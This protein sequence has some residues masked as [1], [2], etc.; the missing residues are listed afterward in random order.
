M[1]PRRHAT[2]IAI[3]SDIHGNRPALEA[4][5]GA[6]A[7]RDITRWWCLGDLVGYGADPLF[8]M[9]TCMT[10]AARC[11]AGNHDLAAAGRLELDSFTPSAFLALA[12]TRQTLGIAGRARL[13]GL[14]PA[15]TD[16]EVHLFHAS[17][18]DHIWEYVLTSTQAEDCLRMAQAHL[19]LVGH[20][21]VPDAWRMTP[22]GRL[23]RYRLGDGPLSL[24]PGRWLVNPGSVGQPRDRDPRAAWAVFDPGAGTLELVRT[25]YDV[26]AAQQAIRAADLPD[27]LADRLEVGR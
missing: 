24:G 10:G 6:M 19:T 25:A 12:W 21:H 27:Q 7:A 8:C 2:S 17:P 11:L 22:T 18:R 9:E 5:L 1:T 15:D 26:A 13:A 14:E 23:E 20:T 4:V 16:G 3:L